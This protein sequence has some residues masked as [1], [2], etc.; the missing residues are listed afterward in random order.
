MNTLFQNIAQEIVSILTT[1]YSG[2]DDK[3]NLIGSQLLKTVEQ[4]DEHDIS[5][6]IQIVQNY[7]LTVQDR[8]VVFYSDT[9][10]QTIGF[11]VR[12]YKDALY[13]IH[14]NP[15]ITSDVQIG[16]CIT[17]IDKIPVMELIHTVPNRS[18]DKH[19]DKEEWNILLSRAHS[20]T[21]VRNS[22]QS[23]V[24]L[25]K[26][27]YAPESPAYSLSVLSQETILL[28][29]ND[30]TDYLQAE[31]LLKA[32]HAILS[33]TVNLIIDVRRNSG[34]ID[35]VWALFIELLFP[36]NYEVHID[37]HTYLITPRNLNNRIKEISQYLQSTQDIS[38][39]EYLNTLKQY[40]GNEG[41]ITMNTFTNPVLLT[42]SIFPKNVVI[43]TDTFCGS[44]GESFVQ[45][46]R[47]SPKVTLLGRNTLGCYDYS[48]VAYQH[49]ES[50]N[51]TLQYPTS[52]NTALDKGMGIDLTGIVPDIV[53]E[54]TP[55]HLT[56]DVDVNQALWYLSGK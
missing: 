47:L 30:F 7:L 6:F 28:I 23:I 20:V 22:N 39:Q 45:I 54:W 13:V 49:F 44:S 34:G 36:I 16:D 42:G 25:L 27:F 18:T 56:T 12:R 38:V 3:K 50:I 55:E 32:N 29:F 21:I 46:A 53:V 31:E 52:R 5:E 33:S 51:C 43:L 11:Q 26:E 4:L 24:P 48:N 2:K 41:W 35:S 1:D 8:H 17:A 40:K 14:I 15:T 37:E 9:P 10:S 19:I